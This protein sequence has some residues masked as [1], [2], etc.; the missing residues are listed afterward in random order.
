M[1]HRAKGGEVIYGKGEE[2]GIDASCP[3]ILPLPA[4]RLAGQVHQS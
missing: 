2:T 3:P 4:V 1:G